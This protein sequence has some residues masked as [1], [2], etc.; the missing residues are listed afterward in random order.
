MG[1]ASVRAADLDLRVL[2]RIV[3]ERVVVHIR[4][5]DAGSGAERLVTDEQN[6]P[7]FLFIP[8]SRIPYR[9]KRAAPQS[10]R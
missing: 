10:A 4:K 5:I 3:D 1:R 8:R 7:V 6:G 9:R 2:C